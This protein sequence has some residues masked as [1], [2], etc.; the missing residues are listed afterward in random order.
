[1][2]GVREPQRAAHSEGAQMKRIALTLFSVIALAVAVVAAHRH[3]DSSAGSGGQS[4]VSRGL[5]SE[6]KVDRRP[7][8]PGPVPRPDVHKPDGCN[9]SRP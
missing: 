5:P 6:H 4:A 9:E 1:M 3:E 7:A 2:R 8:P